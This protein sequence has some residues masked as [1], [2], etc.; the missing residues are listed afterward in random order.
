MFRGFQKI[1]DKIV[2]VKSEMF[3][4]YFKPFNASAENYTGI[5]RPN[6][7]W[8]AESVIKDSLNRVSQINDLSGS[9]YHMQQNTLLKQPTLV[10]NA[11]NGQSVLNFDGV[12]DWIRVL[13]GQSFNQPNYY[14]I[15]Y[16]STA[17]G[18]ANK[19]IFD[20]SDSNR[21]YLLS[22]GEQISAYAGV[23]VN[24]TK[25]SP[26]DYI[27]NSILFDGVRSSVFE[28]GF[29]KSTGNAGTQY[30]NGIMLGANYSGIANHKGGIAE[31]IFYSGRVLE[32]YEVNN[33][34]NYLIQKYA[35]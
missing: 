3:T 10:E 20:G 22:N 7:W 18:S 23:G 33:I 4:G 26:F 1:G 24:Y 12:D 31:I 11:I 8:S 16:N 32:S 6:G 15:V 29:F 25:S 30:V 27:L 9:N 2:Y 13:F 34:N 17:S 19:I 35:L 14:F 21:N 28:N 5:P